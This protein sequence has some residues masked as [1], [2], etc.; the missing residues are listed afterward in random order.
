MFLSCTIFADRDCTQVR[1]V[2]NLEG[3]RARNA[4]SAFKRDLGR[5]PREGDMLFGCRIDRIGSEDIR[6]AEAQ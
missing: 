6:E 2:A 3:C 5:E 4:F 1:S